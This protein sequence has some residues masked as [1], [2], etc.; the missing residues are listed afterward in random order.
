MVTHIGQIH[1]SSN[2]LLDYVLVVPIFHCNLLVI[3]QLTHHSTV[4]I[5]FSTSKSILQDHVLLMEKEIG[6]LVDDLYKLH[7]HKL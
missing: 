3:Y 5:L 7:I 1:L 2:I 4:T 6:E